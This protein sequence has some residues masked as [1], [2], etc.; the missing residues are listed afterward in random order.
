MRREREREGERKPWYLLSRFETLGS[1]PSTA[2]ECP[3][4]AG[5]GA[6]L[7]QHSP[8]MHATLG[9]N[10]SIPQPSGRTL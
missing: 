10:S 7:V 6:Q 9:S 1:I 5:C 3:H 2:N 8:G 4:P